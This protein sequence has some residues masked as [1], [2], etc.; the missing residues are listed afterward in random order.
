M[1]PEREM[2]SQQNLSKGR[3]GCFCTRRLV[4]GHNTTKSTPKRPI[5]L[6]IIGAF[7]KNLLELGLN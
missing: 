6:L 3:A 1:H 4:K 5:M 7:L 2:I